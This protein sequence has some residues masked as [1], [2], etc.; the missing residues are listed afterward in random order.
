[1]S[2]NTKTPHA[3]AELIHKWAEDTSQVVLFNV[4]DHWEALLTAAPSWNPKNKYFLVCEE[5]VD[6]ALHWLNGGQVEI[7]HPQEG[8]FMRT[9]NPQFVAGY[10]YRKVLTA[11]Q[12]A[13]IG[14]LEDYISINR[15]VIKNLTAR[16]KSLTDRTREMEA[17]IRSYEQ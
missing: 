8:T 7:M 1:M 11:E 10:V 2:E 6:M 17:K 3:H 9:N 5:H 13:E 12:K 16:A 14:E 15:Q 4:S